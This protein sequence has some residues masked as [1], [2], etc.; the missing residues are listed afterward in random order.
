MPVSAYTVPRA[1]CAM[2]LMWV[3]LPAMNRW[4]PTRS[5]SRISLL[6]VCAVKRG[7]ERTGG[8]VHLE[9]V[10]RHRHTGGV[11]E[12]AGDVD[13]LVVG[14]AEHLVDGAVRVGRERRQ[15][16]TGRRVEGQQ[17]VAREGRGGVEVLGLGE[18]AA[19]HDGVAHLGD[20]LDGP[21]QDVGRV[22]AGL[23]TDD[24]AGLRIGVARVGGLGRRCPRSQSRHHHGDEHHQR[25]EF[26]HSDHPPVLVPRQRCTRPRQRN[27]PPS[28]P[29]NGAIKKKRS[30]PVWS[31]D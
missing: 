2:P 20:R 19:D 21:V 13:R 18:R 8:D 1:F 6:I 23:V 26:S 17:V 11:V 24:L 16:P 29:R 12:G 31:S 3:N 10:A 9:Q 30:Q 28:C 7:V 27:H 25:K 22:G 15:Q 4:L 5:M 14:S